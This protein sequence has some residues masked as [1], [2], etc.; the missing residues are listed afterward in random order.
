MLLTPAVLAAFAGLALAQ[1]VQTFL[2][3]NQN[4]A[5][6]WRVIRDY[7][8]VLSEIQNVQDVTLLVPSGDALNELDLEGQSNAEVENLLRYHV[9]EGSYSTEEL[10]E[11][12]RPFLPTL[13]TDAGVSGGQ[14]VQVAGSGETVNIFSGLNNNASVHSDYVSARIGNERKEILRRNREI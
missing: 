7:P 2:S 9:L 12:D 10:L 4:S 11:A 3:D 8:D 1:D 14:R 13:M 5:P 6:F